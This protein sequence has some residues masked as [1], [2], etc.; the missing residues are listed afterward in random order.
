MRFFLLF[1]FVVTQ[2]TAQEVYFEGVVYDSKTNET[3]P[4]VNLSFLE[5]L[6]G[7]S[8]DEE[9]HFFMDLP[10]SYLDKQLHLSSL[11]YNDTVVSARSVFKAKKFKMVPESFE[12]NEVVVTE[13]LGDMSVLNP[14]SSSSLVS[15]FSSSTTPWVLALYFPNIGQQKKYVNK[16]TIFFQK[17]EGFKGDASKFRIRL[18]D[19]DPKTKHP[20][21]DLLHKSVVLETETGKDYVSIDLSAFNIKMPQQ[22][23]YIGLEWLFV[24]FNWYKNTEKNNITNKLFVEDRFAPTFSGMYS[25]NQNYKVMVYGMGEW[26]DFV[27]KS[28]DKNQ[29]FIPA[30]S[31]K[32]AKK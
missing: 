32:L 15:G 12:L 29:N 31:L 20:T 2:L 5:T 25:K 24:P 27:V 21:K 18:Y 9:G 19:V 1:L 23:V 14:I 10:A 17:N 30:V 3:V 6:K 7:T 13:T 16:V 28:K 22:G 11:G 4:F 26:V 8:S